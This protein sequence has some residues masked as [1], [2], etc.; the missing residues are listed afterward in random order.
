M[1]SRKKDKKLNRILNGCNKFILY[2][3]VTLPVDPWPEV[4]NV[5]LNWGLS[6]AS[7]LCDTKII[8]VSLS[9]AI[10]LTNE[11]KRAAEVSSSPAVGSSNINT[12]G[13]FIIAL[14]V[15]INL[16]CPMVR[17]WKYRSLKCHI[18]IAKS[19]SLAILN[20]ASVGLT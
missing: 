19:H 14:V 7:V 11:T 5:N 6:P 20:C 13:C 16:F 17:S 12:N 8:L 2:P 15:I 18:L 4:V 3:G 1:A 10:L 9:L